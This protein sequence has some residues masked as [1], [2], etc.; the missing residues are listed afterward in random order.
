LFAAKLKLELTWPS[1]LS[2]TSSIWWLD[3]LSSPGCECKHFF[4][5]LE[6]LGNFSFVGISRLQLL[7][8]QSNV[9]NSSFSY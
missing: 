9:F 7:T 3:L 4:F 2:S 6:Q 8:D 5:V 1:S